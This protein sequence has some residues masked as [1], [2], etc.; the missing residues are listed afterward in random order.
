VDLL[1]SVYRL[2]RDNYLPVL[3][4]SYW[5]TKWL[6]NNFSTEQLSVG[7]VGTVRFLHQSRAFRVK[8]TP[9]NNPYLIQGILG[10]E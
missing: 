7:E 10:V 1:A 4:V 3:V 6:I 9:L 2:T 8:P 5:L